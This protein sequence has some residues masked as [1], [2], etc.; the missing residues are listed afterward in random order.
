MTRAINVD[1]HIDRL[2]KLGVKAT[3]FN[4]IEFND[5]E[6]F[7]N[8]LT[9]DFNVNCTNKFG[10]TLL[11]KAIEVGNLAIIRCL[12]NNNADLHIMDDRLN[13]ALDYARWSNDEEIV[14]ILRC[15]IRYEEMEFAR[16]KRA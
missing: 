4:A 15:R 7:V 9:V 14:Q 13:M 10:Q 11:M 1:Y 5:Y 12:I 8:L 3:P 6:V 2:R 16:N